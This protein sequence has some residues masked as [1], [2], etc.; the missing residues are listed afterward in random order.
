MLTQALGVAPASKLLLST[1]GARI[2]E[3]VALGA[4]TARR[5]LAMALEQAV[6]QGDLAREEAEEVAAS[7]VVA[8][9]DRDLSGAGGRQ[10][11]GLGRPRSALGNVEQEL[12]TRPVNA[13]L[14]MVCYA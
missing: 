2:P 3:H 8:D 1:D 12:P 11:R 5:A 13:T 14:A 4:R 7:A 6:R 9:G 10:R